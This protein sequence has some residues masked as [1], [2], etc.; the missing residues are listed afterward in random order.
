MLSDKVF[1]IDP[2]RWCAI[3]EEFIADK[4]LEMRRDGIA[5]AISGGLDSSL[6]AALCARAVGR[7]KVLGLMLPVR[8]GNPEAIRYGNE[9]VRH[10]G[11]HS[12]RIGISPVLRGMRASSFFLSLMSG[13]EK[14]KDSVEQ[15]LARKG[16]STGTNYQKA[17]RGNLEP[18][19]RRNMAK[20]SS[21]NR[22]RMLV[23]YKIAEERN[24][25]VAGS[26]HRTEGMLGLFVK[27]GID[28]CADIMPIKNMYR[29]H[30]RQ[31]A[32]YI[33]LPDGIL[34]RSPNPD[35][36]PGVVDKYMSYFSMDSGML[37]LILYGAEKGMSPRAIADE[38]GIEASKAETIIETVKL[39]GH[40]RNHSMAPVLEY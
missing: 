10:L 14:W 32:E 17:L 19:L 4:M 18:W 39:T 24:L 20:I 1:L 40:C 12:L 29:S 16:A 23:T 9:I 25:M 2:E 26:A 28:D 15:Y 35:I 3:I 33:G 37:D 13:R 7:E 11:I 21:I 5:V 36:I 34:G 30:S 8:F 31:L 38:L 6:V 27:Y 22:A